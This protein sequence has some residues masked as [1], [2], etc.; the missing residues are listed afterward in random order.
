MNARPVSIA[1]ALTLSLVYALPICAQTPAPAPLNDSCFTPTN[2]GTGPISILID[3]TQAT[4]DGPPLAG[5]VSPCSLWD[6][7][8]ANLW[9]T[10]TPSADTHGAKFSFCGQSSLNPLG[11]AYSD[12]KIVVFDSTDCLLLN[13]M[14]VIA[15]ADEGCG[16]AAFEDQLHAVCEAAVTPGHTYLIATGSWNQVAAGAWDFTITP[17]AAAVTDLACSTGP[18]ADDYSLTFNYP[19]G[20]AP[21]DTVQITSSE[22]G[23]TNPIATLAF[24]TNTFGAS[25]LP[26]NQGSQL[27]LSL[28]ATFFDGNFAA[29]PATCLRVLNPSFGDECADAVLV[30]TGDLDVGF[31]TSLATSSPEPPAN[32]QGASV[33]ATVYEQDLWFAYVASQPH[34]MI[35]TLTPSSS[36]HRPFVSI[37]TDCASA[38]AGTSLACKQ[39]GH[40]GQILY[41]IPGNTYYIRIAGNGWSSTVPGPG[42]LELRALP[43][44]TNDEC[45]AALDLGTGSLTLNV[46]TVGSTMSLDPAPW[47]CPTGGTQGHNAEYTNDVWARWTA[48]SHNVL[49]EWE[50]LVTSASYQLAAYE[51][52]AHVANRHPIDCG[53]DS[54]VTYISF[55]TTPGHTYHLRFA[56]FGATPGV[57]ELR[58][59]SLGSITNDECATALPLGVGDVS[60]PI[61]TVGATT[62]SAPH[63]GP[64]PTGSPGSIH[65]DQFFSWVAD[66]TLA[67]VEF[68]NQ[69]GI[70]DPAV[71][72]YVNC[73]YVAAGQALDCLDGWSDHPVHFKFP[74][75]PGATYVLRVAD[76]RHGAIGGLGDLSIQ[77]WPG[78]PNDE[79]AT[80]LHLGTGNHSTFVD[81]RQA[82]S[83]SPVAPAQPCEYGSVGL[84]DLWYSWTAHTDALQAT[85]TMQPTV[86]Y[87]YPSI[88]VYDTCTNAMLGAPLACNT[89]EDS[90]MV[91]GIG[92]TPGATYLI[93]VSTN[94][95]GGGAG[96]LEVRGQQLGP[97]DLSCA[98][99][100]GPEDYLLTWLAPP[101]VLPG[102]TFVISSNEAGAVN[103]LLVGTH[104]S[105]PS[106]FSGSLLPHNQ[107]FTSTVTFEVEYTSSIGVG[108][109][110]CFV[111]FNPQAGDECASPLFAGTG[112]TILTYDLHGATASIEPAPYSHGHSCL[113]QLGFAQDLWFEWTADWPEV[114]MALTSANVDDEIA[115]YKSCAAAASAQAV[116]C[117]DGHLDAAIVASVTVGS[118]YRVRVGRNDLGPGVAQLEICEIATHLPSFQCEPVPSAWT[119]DPGVPT[120]PS[121]ALQWRWPAGAAAGDSVEI[122]SDEPG[123]PTPALTIPYP[124]QSFDYRLLA[125][126]VGQ[127][128]TLTFTA[129]YRT[130]GARSSERTCSWTFRSLPYDECVHALPLSGAF[131]IQHTV[132]LVTTSSSPEPDVANVS[133]GFDTNF[134]EDAWVSWTATASAITLQWTSAEMADPNLALYESCA[135]ALAGIAVACNDGDLYESSI[136]TTVVVGQTYLIRLGNDDSHRLDEGVFTIDGRCEDLDQFNAAFDCATQVVTL[137]WQETDIYT[138]LLL[139]ANGVP[140]ANQPTPLGSPGSNSQLD[141]APLLNADVTYELTATCA[142]GGSSHASITIKTLTPANFTNLI[143]D[144][145]WVDSHVYSAGALSAA[146]TALGES[147][148]IARQEDPCLSQLVTEADNIWAIEGTFPAD[149]DLS[150]A[151]GI[152]LHD[153]VQAGKNCYL[154]GSDLWGFH[155]IETP[156][157][158]VDGV[159]WRNTPDGDDSL[160]R[161]RSFDATLPALAVGTALPGPVAYVQ[162]YSASQD[163]DQLTLGTPTS[164]P[165][166]LHVEVIH[167][168]APDAGETDYIIGTVA[169]TTS[170]A[171]TIACSFEIGAFG[172]VA[173]QQ[174]LV[175]EYL[176]TFHRQNDEFQRGD[177][178][179]DGARNIIDPYRLLEYLFP[180]ASGPMALPCTKACDV[181]D[182]G[183]I[184]MA[185][186]VTLLSTLFPSGQSVPWNPPG[187]CGVDPT[188]DLLTCPTS[189]CP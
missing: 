48:N 27:G 114:R 159:D 182:D 77:T 78:A 55:P 110:Q 172:T 99:T 188:A 25:L 80:A 24:P 121:V 148:V 65:L 13:H 139:T 126:N 1:I 127:P 67:H 163:T 93:R 130:R 166:V 23:V 84:N 185:D 60:T 141:V 56:N 31:D 100:P 87:A 86:L 91:S 70:S 122:N 49:I 104:G 181:T 118:T 187:S 75:T 125:A 134:N 47:Y 176:A 42:T 20:A 33:T 152:L 144:M 94:Q 29:M 171:T 112:N 168:N 174:T 92:V 7:P 131:P 105:D 117:N 38:A 101:A 34:L 120:H 147:V 178:N 69:I 39:N 132:N 169:L 22:P 109:A 18:G 183:S 73:T 111:V 12:T 108:T 157:D 98:A 16:T 61:T 66:D 26:A 51:S 90:A 170:G 35:R 155:H 43:T 123:V 28:G 165:G 14:Q 72:V 88:A 85:W 37:H 150:E 136:D 175:G 153:A 95:V 177:C 158:L 79:C 160:T 179:N 145:A 2:L 137:T 167:R 149:G 8:M 9:Y 156:L 115:L 81:T 36:F 68:G 4:W 154:Q 106:S 63:P 32:C 96:T 83:T 6:E 128:L 76:A 186:T 10:W 52:C 180:P 89:A 151:T 3:N 30:G 15:C 17:F 64:C 103:P 41:T 102:D 133:C 57:G 62:G 59:T 135:D 138:S 82:A 162:P 45:A 50:T 58:I 97:A 21:G 142:T 140:V 189:I 129:S 71:L 173:Q 146:L 119:P 46:P 54:P 5:L 184:D 53:A 113:D 116:A 11:V 124:Q 44:P 107:G 164:D 40:R 19:A 74:T 161:V 143:V